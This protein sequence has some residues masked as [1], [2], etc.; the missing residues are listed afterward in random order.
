M[1]DVLQFFIDVVTF[2]SVYVLSLQELDEGVYDVAMNDIREIMEDGRMKGGKVFFIGGDLSVQL[3]MGGDD[4][5]RLEWWEG[6]RERERFVGCVHTKK[7][8]PMRNSRRTYACQPITQGQEE[9][10]K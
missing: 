9:T 7:K 4:G 3:R 2:M 5:G 6:E 10:R 8:T 1:P